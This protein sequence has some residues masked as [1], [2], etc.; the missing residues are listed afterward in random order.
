MFKNIN[1]YLIKIPK[2]VRVVLVLIVFA[3]LI[4]FLVIYLTTKSETSEK[5]SDRSKEYLKSQQGRNESL[6][7]NFDVDGKKSG[8]HPDLGAVTTEDCFSLTIPFPVKEKRTKD[9][10]FVQYLLQNP[11][12]FVVSY[13]RI[14][15]NP[16]LNELSDIQL[17][18]QDPKRYIEEIIKKHGQTYFIYKKQDQNEYEK[19]GFTIDSKNKLFVISL[20][21]NTNENL[22]PKFDTILESIKFPN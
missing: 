10:C 3:G 15:E 9:H 12:G 13:N 11:R 4:F 21:A 2:W 19:I 5:L 7:D 1:N 14:L 20:S 16:N 17:R 6:F 8:I 18:K 22:D